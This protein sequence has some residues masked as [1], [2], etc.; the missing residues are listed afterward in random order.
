MENKNGQLQREYLFDNLKGL[1]I[2]LVV[3]GHSLEMYRENTMIKTIYLFIYTF[4]MPLFIFIAGYFSKN[5]EKCRKTAV[6]TFLIPYLVINTLFSVI[7]TVFYSGRPITDMQIFTPGWALWFLLSMFVWK[8]LLKDLAKIKYILFFSIVASLLFSGIHEFGSYMSLGR[9]IGFLF[10][11]M[12]GYFYQN[13]D[14]LAIRK[15][16]KWISVFIIVGIGVLS[17]YF[18]KNNIIQPELFYF[19]ESYASL[20]MSF[21]QGI[22]A[23]SIAYLIAYIM[24]YQVINLMSG[25]QTFLSKIGQS[26]LTIYIFHTY[27][28]MLLFK[29]NPFAGKPLLNLIFLLILSALITYVLSLAFFKR[30]YDKF[31]LFFNRIF[32]KNK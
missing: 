2:F 4:H 25:R 28:V 1:L 27:I 15:T 10:W 21:I 9:T 30:V 19:S 16:P 32:I 11:F 31:F 26:S 6:G 13:E 14:I 17:Y 5:A 12:L 8:M 18:T 23:R 24:L 3:F 7:A 20:S 22:I 29:M